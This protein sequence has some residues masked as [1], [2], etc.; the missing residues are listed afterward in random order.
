MRG[1]FRGI[2]TPGNPGMV[3]AS[4]GGNAVQ[5]QGI[6]FTYATPALASLANGATSGAINIQFDA[7]SVFVWLRSTFSAQLSGPAAFTYSSIP[8]PN[9]SVSIQ[10]TGK[11]ASFMNTF[12]PVYQIASPIPGFPYILPSPQLIQPNATFAWTFQNYDGSD[13]YYNLQFQLHGFRVF[14]PNITNLN[15]ALASL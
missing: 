15:Q 1:G 4:M 9:I 6:D 7:N 8:V 5:G 3:P 12:I 13:T 10:D 2:G 11:G 14:N